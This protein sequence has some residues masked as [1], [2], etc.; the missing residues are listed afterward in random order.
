[1]IKGAIG[2][3]LTVANKYKL[4]PDLDCQDVYIGRPSILGNP[5][6]MTAESDRS[7]VIEKYRLW[8]WRQ[9]QLKGRVYKELIKIALLVLAGKKIRLVCY[10]SPK[11]CH[12]DIVIKAVEW[13]IVSGKYSEVIENDQSCDSI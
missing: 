1:M 3:N 8:L 10:C 5:F 12:G 2:L 4:S 7:E 11:P 13:L 6:A 9:I